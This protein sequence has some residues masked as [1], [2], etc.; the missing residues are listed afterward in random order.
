[1]IINKKTKEI[2][3]RCDKPNENWLNDNENFYLVYDDSELAQKIRNFY[4]FFV[5]V[6]DEQNNLVDVL[7]DTTRKNNE[8]QK[9]EKKKNIERYKKE[10][11]QTSD[12]L[13]ECFEYF[14]NKITNVTNISDLLKFND[15]PYDLSNLLKERSEIRNKINELENLINNL[16]NEE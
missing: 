6:L 12:A 10:L 8:K 14:L 1:M 9:N 7:E 4:P 13:I 2:Q 15:Y 3:T 11:L 5:F 16:Q